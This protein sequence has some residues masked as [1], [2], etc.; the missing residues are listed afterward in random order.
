MPDAALDELARKRDRFLR[1][2]ARPSPL[3]GYFVRRAE[4]Y[5]RERL[6]ALLAR[7]KTAIPGFWHAPFDRL[8]DSAVRRAR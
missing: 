1:L 3:R 5:E 2:A 8:A 6:R 7:Y 4:E